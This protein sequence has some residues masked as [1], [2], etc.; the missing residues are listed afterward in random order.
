MSAIRAATVTGR[1]WAIPAALGVCAVFVAPGHAETSAA[2]TPWL[3]PNRL[4]ARSALGFT[5]Q[6]ADP[7]TGEPAPV[8]RSVLRFPAGL[9]L[10]VPHLSSCSP[11]RLR[12]GGAGA[13][14]AHSALGVGHALVDTHLGSQTIAENI[15]LWVFLG[16]PHNLQPTVEILGQGY[17]PIDERV[18]LAGTMRTAG[19]PYGE[20]LTLVI[21]PIPTLP[22]EPDASIA[23]FSLVIG[24]RAQRKARDA[25]TIR[26][27]ADCPEDGFPFA[28]EFTYADGSNS[29]SSATVP[30]PR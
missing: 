2:V 26:L 29:S 8:R 28:A 11:A 30:C 14:P 5:I 27:P 25:N 22:L 24:A 23:T 16:R 9:T 10:D 1:A 17:T 3:S 13:C 15:S 18:V 6:F 20:A 7:S 19:G 21:P 12:V 4:G